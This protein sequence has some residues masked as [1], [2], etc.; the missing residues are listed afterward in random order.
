MRNPW[1]TFITGDLGRQRFLS[2]G[3]GE[4]LCAE[5]WDERRDRGDGGVCDGWGV[6]SSHFAGEEEGGGAG[7]RAGDPAAEHDKV[8]AKNDA[9][10]AADDED[11]EDCD[12][13]APKEED[14]A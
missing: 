4:D 3:D 6:R 1:F 8:H 13:C 10:E 9:R 12:G 5:D 7:H 14:Q 11:G 2:G